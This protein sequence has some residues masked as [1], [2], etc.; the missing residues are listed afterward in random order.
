MST[1]KMEGKIKLY[2]QETLARKV[3][4]VT[5]FFRCFILSHQSLYVPRLVQ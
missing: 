4:I 3:E 5:I 1:N 2:F